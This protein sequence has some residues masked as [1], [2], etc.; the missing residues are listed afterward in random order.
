M[1]L[2]GS[3]KEMLA[4]SAVELVVVITPHDT[5]AALGLEIVASGRHGVLEK[6]MAITTAECDV[7]IEAAA[8]AGVVVSTYH[9]RHWDGW[10]LKAKEVVD[11]GVIGEV[12]RVDLAIGRHGKP[13][14]W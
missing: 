8:K 3:V 12:V 9:N 1:R 4:K 11:F 5:H 13:G 2:S 10:I 14:K 7:M 6:P